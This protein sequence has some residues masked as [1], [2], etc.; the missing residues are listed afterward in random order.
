MHPP[1]TRHSQLFF[2]KV[3]PS[4]PPEEVQRVFE[5]YGGVESINLF[6]AWATARSSKGCGLITM[7]TQEGARA[8]RDALNG[9]HVWEGADAPMA[10]E[11][12]CP[13]KLGSKAANAAA[14]KAAGRGAGTAAARGGGGAAR[15]KR[16]PRASASFSGPTGVGD[17]YFG[18]GLFGGV[19]GSVLGGS[20]G[21]LLALSG[22]LG[23]LGLMGG[24]DG[25]QLHGGYVVTP[26]VQLPMVQQGH[27]QGFS[28]SYMVSAAGQLPPRL[29]AAAL[30]ATEA[31]LQ[32]PQV[33]SGPTIPQGP[34]I[35]MSSPLV[36]TQVMQ[37]GYVDGVGVP[38]QAIMLPN[39]QQFLYQQQ[40]QVP[41][42]TVIHPQM[43]SAMGVPAA[44]SRSNP[45]PQGTSFSPSLGGAA[46]AGAADGI[47]T[48]S[49][50]YGGYD[51]AAGGYGG[52]T[53]GYAALGGSGGLGV[54]P[55]GGGRRIPSLSS[56]QQPHGGASGSVTPGGGSPHGTVLSNVQGMGLSQHQ[57]SNGGLLSVGH[58]S[59]M[60]DGQRRQQLLQTVVNTSEVRRVQCLSIPRSSGLLCDLEQAEEKLLLA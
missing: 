14:S 19:S 53:G 36:L 35:A 48:T 20:V 57:S 39:G 37:N 8:A 5:P 34:L 4:A 49:G 16:A 45:L 50:G 12:C 9:K 26:Q 56:F 29:Q 1:C 3:A 60:A 23:E 41:G 27:L 51:G 44:T 46:G 55:L 11:W 2:A 33:S 30:G 6:R 22:G 52:G 28:G 59:Q 17:S 58:A 18:M 24:A 32:L 43:L 38:M 15:P 7:A 47:V 10:V 42:L 21:R 25:G 31:S 54:V 13:E 40:Q